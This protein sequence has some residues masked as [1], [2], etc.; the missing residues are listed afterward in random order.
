MWTIL[1]VYSISVTVNLFSHRVACSAEFHIRFTSDVFWAEMEQLSDA[2]SRWE[3]YQDGNGIQLQSWLQRRWIVLY[4]SC[5]WR[6]SWK[7]WVRRWI[8]EKCHTYESHSYRNFHV[9]NC[10]SGLNKGFRRMAPLKVP[11]SGHSFR[12]IHKQSSNRLWHSK[13][14]LLCR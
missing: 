2:R 8:L 10:N 4:H 11:S 9:I 13:I 6:W 3:R 1:P 14:N 7:E 5:Y 12:I